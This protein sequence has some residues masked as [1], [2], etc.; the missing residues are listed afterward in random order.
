M[1]EKGV[2]ELFWAIRKL[3]NEYTHIRFDF[4]GWY[5]DDYEK[6]IHEMEAENIIHYYG[7]K[8]NVRPYIAKVHCVIL[9]SYHEG[10]SNTLLESAAMGKPLITSNI[11]GCKEAV[12]DGKTGF[13]TPPRDAKS[14]YEKIKQFIKLP[15]EDK[16]KMGIYGRR[17][18][19]E[20][21]DKRN[22][23]KMTIDRIGIIKPFNDLYRRKDYG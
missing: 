10:M 19:E 11:H 2:D 20:C 23:V 15:Y 18:M 1:R 13:L 21:F 4:I 14:L 6:S 9:P 16:K 12:I 17:L 22:V 5:E 7:F 3:K 8:Q